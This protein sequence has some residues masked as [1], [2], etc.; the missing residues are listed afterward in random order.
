MEGEV[1]HGGLKLHTFPL[2]DKAFKHYLRSKS[3]W[4]VCPNDFELWEVFNYGPD[5][6]EKLMETI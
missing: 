3:K 6:L 4:T 5:I 2:F 1:H